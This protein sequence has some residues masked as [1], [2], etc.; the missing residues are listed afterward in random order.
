MRLGERPTREELDDAIK[1]HGNITKMYDSSQS[2][3]PIHNM[4]GKDTGYVW[5]TYLREKEGKEEAAIQKV[6]EIAYRVAYDVGGLTVDGPKCNV[7][8]YHTNK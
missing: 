3:S 5:F 6:T 2:V 7:P 8:W 4:E 1:K